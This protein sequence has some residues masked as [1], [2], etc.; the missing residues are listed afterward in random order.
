MRDYEFLNLD[1]Q[2]RNHPDSGVNIKYHEN[3]MLSVHATSA[4][5]RS[6]CYKWERNGEDIA[7]PK[8]SGVNTSTLFIE[9]F[10]PEHEG[11]YTCIVS[12]GEEFKSTSTKLKLGE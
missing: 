12:D 10:S 5:A 8:C 7:H 3:V 9:Y 6:L 2:I 1:I 4:G 11:E